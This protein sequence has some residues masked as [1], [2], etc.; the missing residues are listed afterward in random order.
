[1]DPAIQPDQ[2]GY[3]KRA[4]QCAKENDGEYLYEISEFT[5]SVFNRAAAFYLEWLRFALDNT[6]QSQKL[7]EEN[8]RSVD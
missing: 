7:Q 3:F 5:G 6:Y 8:I 2:S 1:M 4:E